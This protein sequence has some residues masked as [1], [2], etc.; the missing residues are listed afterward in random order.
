MSI[1]EVVDERT[2][3]EIYLEGFRRVVQEASP[4]FFMAAY[5]KVNGT[6]ANEHPHLLNEILKKEWGYTGPI[7][8]D[9]GGNH[10]RVAG[11]VAG[12]TLEMP[13]SNGITDKEIYQAVKE[14]MLDELVVNEQINALLTLV[15]D[16]LAAIKDA[17]QADYEAHHKLAIEA[18]ARSLVLLKNDNATLPISEGTKVALIGDFAETP[19]YQGAG[20]SLVNPTQL[21]SAKEAF[22]RERLIKIIGYEAGFKRTGGKSTLLRNRALELAKQSDVAIVFVGLDEAKEAEGIDRKT[23]ALP[24]NQLALLSELIKVHNKVVVVIAAGGAVELPFANEVSAIIHTALGG[25]GVG[26][27]VVDCITGRRNPSGKLAV[28]YPFNYEDVPTAGLFPGKEKTSEHREGLFVGY[29]YYEITK[30]AVRYPF[31]YGL[32]YTNFSYSNLEATEASVTF[33]ITNEGA[34][35]GDEVAQVYIRLQSETSVFRPVRELKGFVRV[36]LQPGETKRVT[37]TLDDHA[38]AYYSVKAGK[39]CKLAG[40]YSIEV[41]AS[42][43]DVRLEATVTIKGEVIADEY[44]SQKLKSYYTGAV[45]NVSDSEF[46]ALL[47]RSLPPKLW[48]R[49]A[50]LEYDDTIAQLQYK[51]VLG[52]GFYGL[53]SFV[54]KILFAVKKPYLANNVMFVM[55]LPFSKIPGFSNGILSE[56]IVKFLFGIKK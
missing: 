2:L 23:M 31:G 42:V 17:P 29:R 12:T 56:K 37:V 51:G 45:K 8:S 47:G 16:T 24:D 33:S 53:L 52:R 4:K 20:S 26:P 36:S 55:N 49:D 44:D 48:D 21:A 40:E 5:N 50:P 18:A 30:T 14:D 10:D 9:W 34:I 13:S 35:A 6:Y 7:V 43:Q 15:Y 39:W 28:S 27:A 41:S 32:S 1:D 54:Q 46:E 22:L 11:L 25:Q 38:F 19:R 3:R